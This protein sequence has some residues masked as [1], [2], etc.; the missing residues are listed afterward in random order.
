MTPYR[1]F[2]PM[3]PAKDQVTTKKIYSLGEESR[4]IAK[5]VNI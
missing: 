3:R 5:L 2:T 4:T 1:P